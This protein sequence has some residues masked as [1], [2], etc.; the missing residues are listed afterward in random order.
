MSR[1]KHRNPGTRLECNLALTVSIS[2]GC[3]IFL[4]PTANLTYNPW[5]LAGSAYPTVSFQKYL[6]GHMW[7]TFSEI[8][9]MYCLI[10]TTP[11]VTD[12]SGSADLWSN[13]PCVSSTICAYLVARDK[14]IQK[15]AGNLFLIYK[16]ITIIG[17]KEHWYVHTKKQIM[18]VCNFNLL[19]TNRS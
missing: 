10:C 6:I 5:V 11:Y 1:I 3:K 15:M 17:H 7:P 13:S 12:H 8:P 9:E 18:P 19:S 14:K 4:C 2:T 16:T